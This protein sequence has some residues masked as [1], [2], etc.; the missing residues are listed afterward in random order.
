MRRRLISGAMDLMHASGLARALAPR[1]RGRGVILTMH[2]VL[3]EPPEAFAPN[4]L[5][6]I[7]PDFLEQA[8]LTLRAEGFEIVGLDEAARRIAAGATGAPFAVLTFDD[9]YRDVRDHGLP[10][11]RRHGCPAT[12]FVVSSFAAGR[13]FLWW[14]AL[15]AAIRTQDEITVDL[16]SGEERI[17]ARD[18]R[19]KDAAWSRIYWNLR[20]GDEGRLRAVIADLAAR[21]DYDAEEDCRSVCMNWDEL[22]ALAADPLVTIGA[23]TVRHYMLGKWPADVARSELEDNRADIERELGIRADHLAYPVGDPAAAGER[24][25]DLARDLGFLTAVTTRPDHIRAR[26]AATMTGLPRVSLNGLFQEQRYLDV[27]LS[28]L[29]F[30]LRNALKGL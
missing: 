20:N 13:G 9:A 27:L 19:E 18:A 30:A 2:H 16:G 3:P 10:V 24:E 29:P 1:T 6:A 15:E 14:R 21:A 5:L 25:F 17:A 26:H 23:H 4:A 7:T 22:R 12:V 11:L 28:G 8:I